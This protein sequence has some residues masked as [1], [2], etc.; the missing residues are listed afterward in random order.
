MP[1][2][3]LSL[4]VL[5]GITIAFMIMVNNNGGEGS[6]WFMNHAAWNGLT[7]TDLVFPTFH[8]CHGRF[9][10]LFS[11]RAAGPR[12]HAGPGNLA[13]A[14]AGGASVSLRASWATAF[15]FRLE[16]M[17]IYGVL[18]RI[19]ICYLVVG[20][21][22]LLDRRVW[23][24]IAALVAV[25]AGYWVLVRWV[26]VP[27]AGLP[28]RDIP[29]LDPSVNIVNWVDQRIFPH[30]LYEDWTTHNLRDPEGLLSNIPALGTVLLGLARRPVAARA[31][32]GL[33]QKPWGWRQAPRF[34]SPPATSGRC[35]FRSTRRCGP[36]P[37]FW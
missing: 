14:A 30:H 36:A 1:S 15:P 11:Q 7:P 8:V 3:L 29:F 19:A 4:D 28:G 5:R 23:T 25:L 12:R 22:Y 24:K 18:Q 10:R 33:R 9:H 6:W 26:P 34:A 27:G 17:R 21:F 32:V 2:R 35:L 20:L 13:H 16:H 31:K 37:M